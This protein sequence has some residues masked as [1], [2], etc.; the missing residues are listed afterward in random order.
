M[1]I[2][3]GKE[4]LDSEKYRSLDRLKASGYPLKVPVSIVGE[5][6]KVVASRIQR[7]KTHASIWLQHLS[8]SE[9]L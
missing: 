3:K 4:T 6:R 1:R 5:L 2:I 7:T 8:S 9:S